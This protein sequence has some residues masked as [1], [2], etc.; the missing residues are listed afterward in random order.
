V[1]RPES[2]GAVDDCRESGEDDS[3]D[4]GVGEVGVVVG[5]S[6]DTGS[7]GNT[8]FIVTGDL[9][10]TGGVCGSGSG[11]TGS[12]TKLLVGAVDGM[13]SEGLD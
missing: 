6:S 11:E 10:S 2:E 1:S 12:S 3:R 7:G 4:V 5:S 13:P 9:G 8:S